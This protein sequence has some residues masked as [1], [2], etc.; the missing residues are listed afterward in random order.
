MTEIFVKKTAKS[1]EYLQNVKS[2][3]AFEY[4]L[5]S[6][7]ATPVK[8]GLSDLGAHNLRYTTCD[9]LNHCNPHDATN[10]HETT[11][12]V[13]GYVQSGKTMS[14][15]GVLAMARDNGYRVA[16][17]LTG[18]TTNLL[19]QTAD[20]L[21]DDLEM[22]DDIDRF[23]FICNPCD[24][25]APRLVKALR[26]SD[27]PLIVIPILKHRKYIDNLT[28]IFKDEKLK[29]ILDNETVIIIDDEADQASLN[30]FGY[31]N[32]KITDPNEIEKQSATYGAILKLRSKLP[33]NSYIQY[34]ATPQANI[35]ITTM[36][37]LSP[38][39]HTILIPGE[40]YVGG[41]K[42]FGMESNGDLFNGNLIKEIP[43]KEVYHKKQNNLKSMPKSLREAMIMHIWAV[44]LVIKW[45]KRYGIKQLTMMV[46]PTDIIEGNKVFE[47]WVNDELNLW[48]E[49]FDKPEWHE[50]RVTVLEEFAKYLPEAIKFYPNENRP[51]FND[52]KKY[53]PDVVNDCRVYRITGDSDDDSEDIKWNA[54]R[55]NILIGA[56]M[57]NRG[58]TVEK[59]ATTYM[60]RYSTS[61]SNADTIEQRC[62][63]FG[64]KMDYIESC[65]VYLPKDSI[66]DYK[67]Y[68]EH[69][70]ELRSIL[71]SCS[72]LKEYE[73]RVMLSPRLR[74]TRLNVLPKQLVK[75]KLVGWVKFEKMNGMKMV[76]DNK[77]VVESFVKDNIGFSGE[78]TTSNYDSLKYPEGEIKKHSMRSMSVTEVITMLT[79]FTAG[80]V[81]DTIDKSMVIRYLQYLESIGKGHVNVIFMSSNLKRNRKL[82]NVTD[83]GWR[84]ELFQGRSNINEPDNYCGDTNLICNDTI[85][86][87]IHHINLTGLSVTDAPNGETYTI[88]IHFPEKFQTMYCASV[89]KNYNYTE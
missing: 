47:K 38:K 51:S 19:G 21:E 8:R 15:T 63:F 65:R 54:H 81:S 2:G 82:L 7:K 88:A 58:F 25:D 3:D 44:I 34:T 35:L 61:I 59:L 89:A 48:S 30:S 46:H 20:R 87:Q 69:E 28:A 12:L 41:K 31:K 85:T 29:R 55:M 74:P 80:S 6:K 40:D 52:L 53:I 5:Q 45:Y 78:F 22:D 57:L 50:D 24:E 62:R 71:G 32:S 60:P 1:Q 76:M 56:Q 75:T 49:S 77:T 67:S 72:S 39:S 26:L 73:H 17:I 83:E 13:V 43:K 10:N 18:I 11:H 4:F 14:F 42:F 36:D 23:H 68:V 64:Y 33:G 79:D 9:I 70:E 84:V 66:K 37:L 86:I 16:I 27:K